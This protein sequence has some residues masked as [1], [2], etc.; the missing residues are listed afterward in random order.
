MKIS[1]FQINIFN[2]IYYVYAFVYVLKKKN[3][4]SEWL[5]VTLS[6]LKSVSFRIYLEFF[7]WLFSVNL[8]YSKF[9]NKITF[10]FKKID[11]KENYRYILIEII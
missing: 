9:S 2:Y 3:I 7:L 6:I 10:L 4:T 1:Y 5:S 8:S 11:W